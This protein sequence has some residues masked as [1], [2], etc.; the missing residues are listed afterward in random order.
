MMMRKENDMIT[1]E[2]TTEETTTD[3]L[4]QA[5]CRGADA[6]FTNIS[7][8]EGASLLSLV[9]ERLLDLDASYQRAAEELEDARAELRDAN[10]EIRE[11]EAEIRQRVNFDTESD[12]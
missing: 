6:N 3:D 9:A 8:D 12:Y 7:S 4:A 10:A 2:T 11:L 1:E 5:L